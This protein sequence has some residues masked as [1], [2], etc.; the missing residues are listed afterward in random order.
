MK[1]K[2]CIVA[3]ILLL[4]WFFLAMT[5]VY[6]GDGYLVTTSYKGEW[7]FMV[8]PVI[9]LIIFI[10]KEKVG[11]YILIGWHA[12]WF[13]TQFLSHEWY[14]IFNK[15]FMGTTEGKI[16][17]FENAIKLIES[18]TVYIP[19]VYHIIL[20][21]LILIALITTLLYRVDRKESN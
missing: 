21:I 2:H 9:A 4:L 19:D 13:I 18:D 12:M 6:F 1:K 3:N 10:V 5:G 20:H 11:K 14:T 15:G 7:Y 8:I 16:K 17:Y